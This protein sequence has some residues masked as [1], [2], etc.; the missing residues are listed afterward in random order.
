MTTGKLYGIGVG[1]GDPEWITVKGARVLSQCKQIFVPKSRDERDSA[2]LN[3][4][5][6]YLNSEAQVH[7]LSFPMITDQ[8]KLALHWDESAGQLAE[9]LR[10]GEDCCFLTLGDLFL[11]STYIY[12]LRAVRKIL[13]DL[14]V[15]SIPGIN[16]FSAAAA[17]TEFPV[18]EAK[19]QVTIIPTADDLG[20]VR[21]ALSQGGTVV[22]M[23]IGKRLNSILDI[24]EE[25]GLMDQAVFVG[26]AG[27]EGQQIE[28]D[29]KRLRNQ[30]P[31]TGY[32]SIILV[33]AERRTRP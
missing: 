32:L 3:I 20:A 5:Q 21:Q 19:E 25:E 6:G 4:A 29:L 1:P 23:K 17:L 18:G 15:I 24:L 9:V 22:L 27:Q 10:T 7:D 8:K 12:L 16:A 33:H 31:T 13:P 2:A 26:R 28:T 30:I 11:Y 14:E